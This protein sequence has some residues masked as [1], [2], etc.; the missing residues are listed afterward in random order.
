MAAAVLDAL[1]L[2]PGLGSLSAALAAGSLVL[3]VLAAGI[4]AF[5]K[6]PA[7]GLEAPAPLP[8]PPPANQ[9]EAEIV[10]LLA[11]LQEK[12]RFLDF[13]MDDVT[14]CDDA[15]IGAAARVVHQGCTRALREHFSIV[16]VSE[17]AEGSLITVPT[18]GAAG[19]YRLTGKIGG[20]APFRGTLVHKGWKAEA[21]RLPRIVPSSSGGLP[22]IAP[23]EVE[24]R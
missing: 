19:E 10:A 7:R 14:S 16:P 11:L 24:I 13:V 9:A 8:P 6:S 22:V 15:Q 4:L 20:Q 5:S 17:A 18:G 21:V 12:G 3:V 1:L 23:A 2:V